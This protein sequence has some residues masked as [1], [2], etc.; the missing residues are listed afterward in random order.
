MAEAQSLLQDAATSRPLLEVAGLTKRFTAT[1]ALD[2]ID[3][4]HPL[5]LAI[6]G[7]QARI[8]LPETLD[9]VVDLPVGGGRVYGPAQVSWNCESKAHITIDSASS[10]RLQSKDCAKISGE[11][12]EPGLNW[13][14]G[15]VFLSEVCRVFG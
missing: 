8:L 7:P 10:G 12:T 15:A 11:L 4:A 6:A 3:P 2:N 9:F 14:D 1:L 5:L 13:L